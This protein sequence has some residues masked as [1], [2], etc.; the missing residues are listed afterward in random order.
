MS[1]IT[2]MIVCNIVWQFKLSWELS[3]TCP[4]CN[5]QTESSKPVTIGDRVWIGGAATIL[6]GVTIGE[7]SVV[8][9]GSVVE[10][11]QSGIG[12]HRGSYAVNM[13]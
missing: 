2:L 1:D 10:T 13:F 8:G 3:A 4:K 9:A 12:N 11:K 5:T 7:G 6:P